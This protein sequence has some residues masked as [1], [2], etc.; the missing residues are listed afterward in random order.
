MKEVMVFLKAAMYER[1]HARNI[2]Y[3]IVSIMSNYR[4]YMVLN[5]F[6]MIDIINK[7]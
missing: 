2:G 3:L 4:V 6:L 7:I 1:E 5:A